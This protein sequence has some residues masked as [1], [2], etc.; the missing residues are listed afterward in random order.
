[1]SPTNR[2]FGVFKGPVTAAKDGCFAFLQEQS[3]RRL[4]E[5]YV[6]KHNSVLPHS[7]FRGQTPDEMYFGTGDHIPEDL[8]SRRKEARARRL[9]VNRAR[10][11][12]VCEV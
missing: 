6:N 5:Y 7:A 8:E 2:F 4:T 9:A 3:V 10:S 12:R 11:C 1:M